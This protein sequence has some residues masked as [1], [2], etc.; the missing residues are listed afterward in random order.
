MGA[1]QAAGRMGARA[2]QASRYPQDRWPQ[3]RA[4]LVASH[5]RVL[6]RSHGPG[7]ARASNLRGRPWGVWQA[8][9]ALPRGGGAGAPGHVGSVRSS[10]G[11]LSSSPG[12]ARP[13]CGG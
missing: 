3:H 13:E 1:G 8:A 4:E 9:E 6:R 10:R 12:E 7:P 5:P 2:E 11:Q